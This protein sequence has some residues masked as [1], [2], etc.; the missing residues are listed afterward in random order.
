MEIC[1]IPGTKRKIYIDRESFHFGVDQILLTSFARMKKGENL[2]DIGTGGGILLLRAQ[3]LY[4]LNH[5]VGIEVQKSMAD[6]AEKSLNLNH[7]PSEEIK[8]LH[9]DIRELTGH[10]YDY[11]NIIS[12]P[13]YR[14]AGS[15]LENSNENERIS[16]IEIKM[17]LEDLFIFA[18]RSLKYR[19]NLFIVHRPHRLSDLLDCASRYGFSLNRLQ[20][21]HN[22]AQTR[23]KIVLCHFVFGGKTELQIEPP[24]IIY[25]KNGVYTEE[26]KQLYGYFDTCADPDR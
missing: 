3:A 26:V 11:D 24:I 9:G 4:H 18:R 25:D 22:T 14:K 16:R 20:F 8:I 1:Y 12:N 13:P 7:I 23:A 5:C 15:G 17:T 21:S 6:M 19:G 10:F 2:I